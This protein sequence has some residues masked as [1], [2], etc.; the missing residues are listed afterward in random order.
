VLADNEA[1]NIATDAAIYV[2]Q[3][4]NV[5]V[6][7]NQVHDSLIGI[8]IENSRNCSVSGN[9]VF[10]NTLGI[11]VDLLPFLQ[12]TVQQNTVV[13]FNEVHANNRPN[14][15]APGDLRGVFPPGIGILLIGA[16]TT[17]VRKNIVTGNQFRG[18]RSG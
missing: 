2:G 12:V 16:D 5:L 18:S 14:T 10:G 3:S 1:R 4:E 11:L 7:A 15:A 6:T 9:E 17:T 8:E 13:S